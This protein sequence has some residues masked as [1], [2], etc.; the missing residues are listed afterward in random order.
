MAT[1]YW[2]FDS[3]MRRR[4]QWRLIAGVDEVGRG[5]LAGPVCAAAVVLPDTCDHPAIRD[6]K[7]MTPKKRIEMDAFIREHALGYAIACVDASEID[8][9]NILEATRHAMAQ[10]V[11]N[12]GVVVDGLLVDGMDGT[13]AP[14]YPSLKVIGGDRCSLSIAAASIIAKVHRDHLMAD[15]D[16]QYPEYGFAQHKGY[17][18]PLHL[19]A[20]RQHGLSPIHRGS[21]RIKSHE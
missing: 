6:S 10:A 12:L 4:Y 8:R 3:T 1:S 17:G 2:E 14:Q 13:F 11:A 9:I 21:F 20:I 7:K 15:F 19:Q 16:E 18:T 5:P